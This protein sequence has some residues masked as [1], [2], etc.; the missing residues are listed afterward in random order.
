MIAGT[1][2]A[3]GCIEEPAGGLATVVDTVMDQEAVSQPGVKN[4]IR[5]GL[6]PS[7]P[8]HEAPPRS[9]PLATGPHISGPPD[10]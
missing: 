10:G 7:D 2:S 4:T 1:P 3:D 6:G 8:P 5:G 9:Q